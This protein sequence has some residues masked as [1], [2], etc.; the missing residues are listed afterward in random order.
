MSSKVQS[1]IKIEASP[2]QVWAVLGDLAR[3]P[4]YVPGVVAAKV[5]GL[6]RLCLDA[7]GNEIREE[8]S[9]YSEA[10]RSYAF[11]HL[12]VPLPVKGSQGKFTV[13]A[14]GAASLVVLEWEFEPLD[15][16]QEAELTPMLDGATK[17]TLENLRQRVEATSD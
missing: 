9:D 1:Q 4:E 13:E 11:K 2:D 16:T 10:R 8:I 7:Y 14:E 3:A 15:P 12:Q 5:E 6:Q 17:M